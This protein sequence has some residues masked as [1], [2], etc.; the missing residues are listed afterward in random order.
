MEVQKKFLK[1]KG[2][3][4]EKNKGKEHRTTEKQSKNSNI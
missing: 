1:I 4:E 2:K 3:V